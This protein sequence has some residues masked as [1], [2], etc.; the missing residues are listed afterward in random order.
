MKRRQ[1]LKNTAAVAAASAI[2]PNFAGGLSA[3]ISA[4]PEWARQFVMNSDNI[5]III[6]L[7]GGNDA[8]NMLVPVDQYTKLFAVRSAVLPAEN[9]LLK[10]TG[11]DTLKLHPNMTG[12]RDLYDQGKV[13]F[14]QSVGYPQHS[15]SHP[16]ATQSVLSGN[17]ATTLP[18]PTGWIGRFLGAFNPTYPDLNNF[19]T[20]LPNDPLAVEF[21]SYSS[22]L[23]QD[24]YASMSVLLENGAHF[25]RLFSQFNNGI[26]P[27]VDGCPVTTPIPGL[28][29]DAQANE[30]AKFLRSLTQLTEH[31]VNR[32]HQVYNS[33]DNVTYLNCVQYNSGCVPTPQGELTKQLQ[34][35]AR[36][37]NG[38]LKT[39]IYLVRQGGYDTH[40]NQS[41]GHG[42]V[43][44]ELSQAVKLFMDKLDSGL[45]DRVAGMVCTEFGRTIKA[46]GSNGTDHST[47]H[48]TF[49]FGNKIAGGV[50]GTNPVI[51]DAAAFNTPGQFDNLNN[52]ARQFDYREMYA[53]LLRQWF[54]LSQPETD[55]VLE[56][57]YPV[58]P[59]ITGSQCCTILQPSVSGSTEVCTDGTMNYS[60]AAQAGASYFW[61]VT[62]GSIVSGQG[63]NSI[64]VKWA[65]GGNG[66]VKVDVMQQ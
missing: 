4:Y 64:E 55:D 50:L 8:L 36:L 6:Q 66:S 31:Y 33:P 44:G 2:V 26:P 48:S 24:E 25:A 60:T 28:P 40:S 14:M 38:G 13:K 7:E 57:P 46:N 56:A 18:I 16:T 43:L 29:S 45:K 47:S 23:M 10:M 17:S 11:T 1:F 41:G 58:L 62:G 59:L 51:P 19:P 61:T 3:K 49:L 37:I 12:L 15:S 52:I 34:I 65:A 20:N 39:Q 42:A 9:L 5:L 53:T 27:A 63:T 22:L 30:R 54:C 21:G 32:F 35:I